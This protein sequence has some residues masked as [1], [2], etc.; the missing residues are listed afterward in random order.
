MFK[1]RRGVTWAGFT[2]RG[3]YSAHSLGLLLTR[4][5]NVLQQEVVKATKQIGKKKFFWMI[6][7]PHY[8]IYSMN[9]TTCTLVISDVNSAAVR[10]LRYS[11][12]TWFSGLR[13]WVCIEGRLQYGK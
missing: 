3:A 2:E 11:Q 10:F 1:C 12:G 13:G 8:Y 7:R 6:V 4:L 5:R 9:S